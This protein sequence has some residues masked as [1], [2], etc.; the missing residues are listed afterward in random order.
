MK[1]Y[2]AI[3]KKK[4]SGKIENLQAPRTKKKKGTQAGH[5]RRRDPSPPNFAKL[6]APSARGGAGRGRGRSRP[7]TPGRPLPARAGPAGS[8]QSLRPPLRPPDV[9]VI[10]C[11]GVRV[12]D[13]HI[14]RCGPS[15]QQ[16]KVRGS[17]AG[18]RTGARTPG[19]P[20]R[21][22]ASPP[23]PSPRGPGPAAPRAPRRS[24]GCLTNR[25]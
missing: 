8:A 14:C 2:L 21:R 18:A 23:P 5:R 10:Y 12:R 22:P 25:T 4:I 17:S 11:G 16:Q 1:S 7:L 13:G 19:P 20:R 24:G 15:R 6:R 3:K 9:W